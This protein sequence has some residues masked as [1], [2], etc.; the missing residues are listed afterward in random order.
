VTVAG[1]TE[2]EAR[3]SGSISGWGDRLLSAIGKERSRHWHPTPG[4]RSASPSASRKGRAKIPVGIGAAEVSES[5]HHEIAQLVARLGITAERVQQEYAQ[6]ALFSGASR[7]GD[8]M[9]LCQ[10]RRRFSPTLTP[11]RSRRLRQP[12]REVA[13]THKSLRQESGAR[14]NRP[15]RR[16]V[17]FS[18]TAPGRRYARGSRGGCA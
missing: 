15:T 16:H 11:L 9:A 6:I 1:G 3:P 8:L 18:C 5:D 4:R 7:I 17:R 2:H 14:R 13:S 10:R 12:A